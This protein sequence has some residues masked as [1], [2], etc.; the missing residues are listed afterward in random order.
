MQTV[1]VLGAG[2]VTKPLV[3]YLL[4][5]PDFQVIVA[6]RTVSKAEKLI[7]GHPRGQ[8]KTLLVQD[9][10]LMK[11]LISRSDLTI[12]LVPW[13]YHVPVAKLCL[14]LDK[15]M[16]TTSYVSDG[17]RALDGEVR[18]KGLLFLNE[19]G[20]DPGIDHMSA[21]KIIHGVENRGGKVVSFRSYCGGLPAPEANTNPF[22]YKFSW[23][24][25]GVVLAGKNTGRY[26]QDGQEVF[27]PSQDL[28]AHTWTVEIEGVGQLVAYP[29][30]DSIP[31]IDTYGL[32]GTKTMYRGTLRYPGWCQTWKKFVDLGLLDE[33]DRTGLAGQTF[34]Q[35]MQ[36]FIA[37]PTGNLKADLAK[38]L[39]IPE[40]SDI[41]DRFEWLGL[42]SDDPLPKETNSPLDILA[43][44]LLEKMP[45]QK[46]E[47]DMLV[48]HHEFFADYPDLPA[49]EV[50]TSTM[51]DFGIPNGD[52][53][54]SRTVSLPAAVAA[55]MILHGE[56]NATGV[57]IPVQPDIYEPIL[58]E[59]EDMG[60]R[61]K[62][63]TQKLP[64]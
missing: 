52:S 12:S 56:I 63:R 41:M 45:Y 22:G 19:I 6:S 3:R 23:S 59:L 40:D 50:I 14:E 4:D 9:S 37:N 21:M 47:R 57:Q 29:N 61:F 54:M 1:L 49:K 36:T 62:E 2:L 7:G 26:L 16:I 27:V 58:K 30:R 5:Q 17:M 18:E 8:A 64:A 38:Q 60:I 25:R 34:A 51:V 43:A 28:F 20:V 10:T 42:L 31:Y 39:D 35:F 46:G 11:E 53:S 48:L 44:R 33:G 55:K 13:I 32:V 24:P 15:H